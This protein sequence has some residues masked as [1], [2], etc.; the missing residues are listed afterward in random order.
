MFEFNFL[1]VVCSQNDNSVFF[2]AVREDRTPGGKHGSKRGR[3]ED[4]SIAECP[5]MSTTSLFTPTNLSS[6]CSLREPYDNCMTQKLIDAQPDLMPSRDGKLWLL[7]TMET[8]I[9][10][11]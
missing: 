8:C 9:P 10:I 4:G 1:F 2:A 3:A 6:V 11:Y 5:S 7:N